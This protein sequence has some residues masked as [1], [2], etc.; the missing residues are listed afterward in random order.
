MINKSGLSKAAPI[1]YPTEGPRS[2][3]FTAYDPNTFDR[4][5]DPDCSCHHSLG[6]TRGFGETEK[7][8]LE[9]FW[10]QY[11]EHDLN[12]AEAQENERQAR[13]EYGELNGEEVEG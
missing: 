5:A 12:P 11:H 6:S 13:G 4:C 9:N 3:Q 1:A 10:A 7:E 2:M 8:A